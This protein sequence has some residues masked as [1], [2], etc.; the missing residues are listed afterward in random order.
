M[1]LY[2]LSKQ[3][4][5]GDTSGQGG[6]YS[7]GRWHRQGTLI[8]YTAEHLSLAKLEV[9]ANSPTLPVN[10]SVLTLEAPDDAPIKFVEADVLPAD[11]FGLAYPS[12]LASIS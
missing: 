12:E 3:H 4:R 11:W 1:K 7:S 9:L 8:L 6:L 2:R 10:Y 5:A